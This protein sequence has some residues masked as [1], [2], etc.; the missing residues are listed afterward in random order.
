MAIFYSPRGREKIP[1]KFHLIPPKFHFVP[2][3]KIFFSSVDIS[4]LPRSFCGMRAILMGGKSDKPNRHELSLFVN[5]FLFEEVPSLFLPVC[6]GSSMNF[7]FGTYIYVAKLSLSIQ[8]RK[9]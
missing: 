3:W 4:D 9:N 7:S 1:P 2:T 6:K 8:V 5:W